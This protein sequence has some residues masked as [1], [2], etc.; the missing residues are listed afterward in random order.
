MN[1]D[2]AL[3]SACIDGNVYARTY[4][5]DG[6]WVTL[7][8]FQRVEDVLVD[9]DVQF[10]VR[11]TG[12]AAVLHGHDFTLGLAVP[13]VILGAT[14]REVRTI[15]RGL[16]SPIVDAF[17]VC[18]IDA[19]LGEE[20]GKSDRRVSAYCFGLHSANDILDRRS[21]EKL[22]GCAMLIQEHGSLLQASIPISE[23][24]RNPEH[25]IRDGFSG[26][27]ID[28]NKEEFS[29]AWQQ[30]MEKLYRLTSSYGA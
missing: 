4:S 19:V 21:G 11:P 22:C 15:Y 18:G 20:I 26:R 23:P 29:I 17:R 28:L 14:S 16:V 3:L 12:G 2:A 25:V 9:P 5:W 24:I 6:V 10:V 27:P 1:R 7:G 8:R 13:L 30:A